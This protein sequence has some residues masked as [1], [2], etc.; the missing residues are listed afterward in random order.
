MI[1][2]MIN[3]EEKSFDK[4][5]SISEILKTL[6]IEE[7]VIATALNTLVVKKQDYASTYPKSG[8][9]IEFLQFMGGG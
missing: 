1:T 8:D 2:L 6:E 7:K 5:L 9:A 3:G 4:C